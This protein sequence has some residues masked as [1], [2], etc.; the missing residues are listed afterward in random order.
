[1]D[2]VLASIGGNRHA[3]NMVVL[4][5]SAPAVERIKWAV[6]QILEPIDSG[7]GDGGGGLFGGDGEKYQM[8]KSYVPTDG[9]ER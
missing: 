9:V 8:S 6:D 3:T 7:G 4:N 5:E 2:F 1:M